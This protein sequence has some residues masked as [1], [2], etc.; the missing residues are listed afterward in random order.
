MINITNIIIISIEAP[1]IKYIVPFFLGVT[2]IK[3]VTSYFFPYHQDNLIDIYYLFSH[4]YCDILYITY[5]LY[6]IYSH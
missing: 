1:K 2:H 6:I 4:N 5:H 3:S